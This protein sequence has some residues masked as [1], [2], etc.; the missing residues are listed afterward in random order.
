[1]HILKGR[2]YDGVYRYSLVRVSFAVSF[3][4]TLVT[5]MLL[6]YN[7]QLNSGKAVTELTSLF[8]SLNLMSVE[9][10]SYIL[11]KTGLKKRN[12]KKTEDT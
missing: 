10:M 4:F 6:W 12:E 8:H 3:I 7:I 2:G 9:L 5:V 1:M 11:V